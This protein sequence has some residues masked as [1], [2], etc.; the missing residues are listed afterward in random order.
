MNFINFNN[1]GASLLEPST[2]KDISN[3]LQLETKISGY[4]IEQKKK[5]VLDRFYFNAARLLN[6]KPEEI[7]FL[8]STTYGW[9]LFINSLT[10][11][12]NSNIVI[13]DNEYGSNY[14]TLVNLSL[15]HI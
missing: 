8:Q 1:A 3:Y 15:I 6:C 9:N 5:K 11:K 2:K 10:I 4:Y 14:I 12:K 7:S 13:F